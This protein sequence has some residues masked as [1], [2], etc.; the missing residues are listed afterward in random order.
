MSSNKQVVTKPVQGKNGVH[1]QRFH[2]NADAND[3]IAKRV[4]G[5]AAP[6][7]SATPAR[8]VTIQIDYGNPQPIY[9]KAS[10][11]GMSTGLNLSREEA[12]NMFNQ[13]DHLLG[14]N[15]EEYVPAEKSDDLVRDVSVII[16]ENDSY[17]PYQLRVGQHG[18]YSATNMT[19]DEVMLSADA[20]GAYLDGE[21]NLPEPNVSKDVDLEDYI[22]DANGINFMLRRQLGKALASDN[23]RAEVRELLE[24][25]DEDKIEPQVR[26]N[27]EYLEKSY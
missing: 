19:H 7:S 25:A 14:E 1:M 2:V 27:I 24:N 11:Y 17:R 21:H 6:A 5:V 13:L 10:S 18:M 22:R 3:A 20:L 16:D 12:R 4:S 26:S 8:E 15:T 9:L 23:G